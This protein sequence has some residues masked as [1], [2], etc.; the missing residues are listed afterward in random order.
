MLKNVYARLTLALLL[1]VAATFVLVK[2]VISALNLSI[3]PEEPYSYALFVTIA[4]L[5]LIA[6][7][8]IIASKLGKLP[9]S[10]LRLQVNKQTALFCLS[11]IL[12]L[13]LVSILFTKVFDIQF[14]V[15]IEAF[16]TVDGYLTFA[17]LF[18]TLLVAAYQEEIFN[19]A[20]FYWELK[21]LPYWKMLLI[22]Q[23]VF[24][25]QHVLIKGFN[26]ADEVVGWLIAG[27]SFM[28]V[29]T[30]TGSLFTS[31]WIHAVINMLLSIF[32][33]DTPLLQVIKI[34][35][36]Y[37]PGMFNILLCTVSMA[38]TY[39][40]YRTKKVSVFEE[41]YTSEKGIMNR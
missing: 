23:L 19:R 27:M 13:S 4:S 31:T 10:L 24:M 11:A 21:H 32:L 30:K 16:L 34:Q 26:S 41:V 17:A 2:V 25:M 12:L 3:T 18:I 35:H 9:F 36:A 22:S 14:T 39:V 38:L 28:Y 15:Q 20:Y 1:L 8:M 6:V 5:I 29:Y 37:D 33:G 40:V 7:E